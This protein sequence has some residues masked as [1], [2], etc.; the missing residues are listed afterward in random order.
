M[1]KTVL[2]F[3]LYS[4]ITILVLF[5]CS[6]SFMTDLSFETQEVLGYTSMFAALVFVFFGIKSY[7]DKENGGYISFGRALGL[8]LL[9]TLIPALAFGIFDA[10]YVTYVYPE[11]FSEYYTAMQA[12]MSPEELVKMEADMESM[13]FFFTPFGTFLLMFLTVFILGFI[14]SLLSSMILRRTSKA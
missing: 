8:G 11:F 4:G 6:Y 5:L 9:I 13:K 1:K 10:I 2:K 3:G 7:R 14:I 12:K